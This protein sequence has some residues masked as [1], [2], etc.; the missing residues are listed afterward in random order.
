MEEHKEETCRCFFATKFSKS[1]RLQEVEIR[2]NFQI[3][4]CEVDF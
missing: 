3:F 1:G 2:G 4:H